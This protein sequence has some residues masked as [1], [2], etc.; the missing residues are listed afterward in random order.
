MHH[1]TVHKESLYLWRGIRCPSGSV[2]SGLETPSRGSNDSDNV[3]LSG[4]GGGLVGCSKKRGG[5]R[6][7]ELR[8]LSSDGDGDVLG[9]ECMYL[10]DVDRPGTCGVCVLDTEKCA[11][12]PGAVFGCGAAGA[13]DGGEWVPDAIRGMESVSGGKPASFSRSSSSRYGSSDGFLA[14]GR[15]V[16]GPA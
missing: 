4:R 5:S 15:D 14:G 11:N 13:R 16:L 2:N 12:H 7:S 6:E 3:A 8:R 1:S 10:G 9:E